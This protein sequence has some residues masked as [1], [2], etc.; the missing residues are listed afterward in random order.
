MVKPIVQPRTTKRAWAAGALATAAFTLAACGDTN[1]GSTADPAST[2]EVEETEEPDY[3]SKSV[4]PVKPENINAQVEDPGYGVSFTYQG[5][6]SGSQGG[7]VITIAVRNDNDVTLPP[8]AFDEPT[9]ETGSGDGNYSKVDL[10]QSEPS[11]GN[12]N[13]ALGGL[14]L[15]LGVGATTNL[16]YVFDTTP[17]SLWN[18]RLSIGNVVY[19]G[20]LS[21]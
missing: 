17:G 5:A 7:T 21:N 2:I 6:V 18:A 10:L 13:S 1:G 8:D 4:D 15:P 19:E 11:D 3:K 9:L 16:Q 14:D 12:Q 20:N